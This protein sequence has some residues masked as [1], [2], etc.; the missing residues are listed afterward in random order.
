[1]IYVVGSGPAGVACAQALLG[2]GLAVTMLDAGIELDAHLRE[3]VDSLGSKRPAEWDPA[4]VRALKQPMRLTPRGVSLKSAYGSSFPY[5]E[6]GRHV[7]VEGHGVEATASLARG[8]L[9][10][11]WGAT[12]LPY[13]P[14]DIADWPIG[15]QELAPHYEAAASLL[16]LAA[17]KDRLADEFPLYSRLMYPLRPS[18]Q[19][20]ALMEDLES[21]AQALSA[22]GYL[23]GYSRLAVSAPGCVY[24]GLCQYGC[25]YRL[26]YNASATLERL[27][28]SPS[29]RYQP[30][31]VVRRISEAGSTVRIVGASRS[32]GARLTF[33]GTRVFLAC[34]VLSTTKILLAS[35]EAYGTPLTM[36][37]SQLFIVPVLRYRRVP[38]VVREEL[39]TL[40][41]VFV[42][43]LDPSLS[44]RTIHLQVCTYNDN[45]LTALRDMLG[46]LHALSRPALSAIVDRL[47]VVQ[48]FLPS[49][50]SSTIRV[51]LRGDETRSTL[52]LEA[53]PQP[54]TKHAIRAVLASL[55]RHRGSFKA[56]PLSPW[57]RTCDAGRSFHNGG[58]FPM[59]QTP[60]IFESDRW[61]RPWGFERVHA[62]DASIFPSIP[63]VPI[64]FSV[65]ANAH[66]IAAEWAEA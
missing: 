22:G 34:G 42:E 4:S 63:A 20:A 28:A 12:V 5:R 58:T 41:Q 32:T 35:L 47:L 62:V 21:S 30:D 7:P 45:Y 65:V 10:N 23:F 39:Y 60:R 33:D 64:T 61:G 46:P 2:R 26:I 66:R 59:R 15:V 56:L 6:A 29:F 51:T 25:P 18:R 16:G 44:D 38:G 24:C 37:D 55:A 14:V 9:S 50:L 36:R 19:A 54:A 48:G 40:A 13:R 11:V 52:V 53:V 8:G 49:Q 3:V 27:Q 31:V 43:L 17:V 57:L 1:V